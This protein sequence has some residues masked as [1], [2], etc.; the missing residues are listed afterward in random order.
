APGRAPSTSIGPGRTWRAV[1]GAF[2][3]SS[4]ESSLWIAPANHSRQS[5]RDASPGLTCTWAGTSGC[6]RL[7]PTICWSVNFLLL[8]SGNTF[9]GI[10]LSPWFRVV[11]VVRSGDGGVIVGGSGLGGRLGTA[12]PRDQRGEDDDAEDRQHDGEGGA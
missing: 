7:W 4:A 9:C 10:A 2:R 1:R 8:S 5:T 6:Q 3:M 11:G 12:G